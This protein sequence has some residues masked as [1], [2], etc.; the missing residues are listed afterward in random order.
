MNK[1]LSNL[2]WK[3]FVVVFLVLVGLYFVLPNAIKSGLE[4]LLESSFDAR[5][6]IHTVE[7]DYS[8]S[9][10]KLT[11][12][13]V[14]D[15]DAPMTNLFELQSVVIDCNFY[16]ALTGRVIIDEMS[17]EGLQLA[18]PRTFSGELTK[19]KNEKKRYLEDKPNGESL[20]DKEFAGLS[21]KKIPSA[22][23]LLAREPLKTKQLAK[24]LNL[25]S[26]EQEA[27]WKIIE[28]H[29]P[30]KSSLAIYKADIKA[31]KSKKI[32]S[33]DDFRAAKKELKALKKALKSEK[34]TL[35]Q[36]KV[37]IQTTSKDYKHKLK[38]LKAAPEEDFELLK[39]KYQLSDSGALNIA[40]LLFGDQV[41]QI[42]SKGLSYYKKLKPVLLGAGNEEESVKRLRG[43]FVHYGMKNPSV[44]VKALTISGEYAQ[45]TFDAIVRDMSHQPTLI[46]Q[47]AT[48]TLS[49]Q[50]KHNA[51]QAFLINGVIDYRD[52]KDTQESLY[53]SM[54]AYPISHWNIVNDD[55]MTIIISKSFADVEAKIIRRKDVT[56]GS[57]S[58]LFHNVS[59]NNSA[60][61]RFGQEVASAIAEVKSFDVHVNV[62]DNLDNFIIRSNLDDKISGAINARLS[63][64]QKIL[65]NKLQAGIQKQLNK[66]LNDDQLISMLSEEKGVDQ[67]LD[68][69]ENLL[70]FELDS[71]S[72][73]EINKHKKKLKN[74]LKSLF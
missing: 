10:L 13:S 3:G 57:G 72:D 15:K 34:N 63:K 48:L 21:I 7:I 41:Q 29:L 66:A 22:E 16:A 12:V 17:V 56:K 32:K 38:A 26:K 59:F 65:E 39:S 18:T 23:L 43:H 50:N 74:Q 5:A 60:S 25:Y 55:K 71:F 9:K 70:S 40:G 49:A 46:K 58:A 6:S 52:K 8:A 2:R 67:Q 28:S 69:I 54:K 73:A 35:T 19:S 53:L 31:L 45:Y 36:A 14:A 42:S 24:G 30:N 61:N 62:K 4:S 64:Q 47:P 33:L 1:L 44:W 37:F 11:D 68:D 27:Q 51:E 20:L